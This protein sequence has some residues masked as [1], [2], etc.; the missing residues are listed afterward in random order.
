M[1]SPKKCKH[2]LQ[3][4][5]RKIERIGVMEHWICKNCEQHFA[6]IR[7]KTYESIHPVPDDYSMRRIRV[8]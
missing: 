8:T 4:I 3:M 6:S 5:D 2:K 1:T 7:N